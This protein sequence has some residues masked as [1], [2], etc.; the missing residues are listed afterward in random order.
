MF[1]FGGGNNNS[2][3]RNTQNDKNGDDLGKAIRNR[4]VNKFK[5]IFIYLNN[6]GWKYDRWNSWI[7]LKKLFGKNIFLLKVRHLFII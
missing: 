7:C 5:E 4:I 3:N 1:L 6:I 2:N